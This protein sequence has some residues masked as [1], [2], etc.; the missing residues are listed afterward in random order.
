MIYFFLLQASAPDIELGAYVRARSVTIEKQGDA[1][2][3]VHAQPEGEK[4]V[5]V[6]AP[7][8][9]GRKTLENVEVTLHAKASVADPQSASAKVDAGETERPD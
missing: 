5:N 8:A 6:Q 4:L 2:L 7:T 9:N 3:T 1:R